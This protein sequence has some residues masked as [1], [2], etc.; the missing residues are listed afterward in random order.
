M[1]RSVT[2]KQRGG[3]PE[4]QMGRA[5]SRER[6]RVLRAESGADAG[7]LPWVLVSTGQSKQ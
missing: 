6:W 1:E 4:A 2:T 3:G 7:P 5:W